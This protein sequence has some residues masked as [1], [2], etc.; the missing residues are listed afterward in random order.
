MVMSSELEV[1]IWFNIMLCWWSHGETFKIETNATPKP[2][3]HWF[4]C[5][6]NYRIKSQTPDPQTKY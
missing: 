1:D 5:V 3:L 2:M 6:S 4:E